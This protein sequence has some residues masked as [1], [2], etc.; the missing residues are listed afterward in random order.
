MRNSVLNIGNTKCETED[1]VTNHVFLF[2]K[3][4]SQTTFIIQW[5]VCDVQQQKQ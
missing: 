3:L 4:L 1:F 5:N 2:L